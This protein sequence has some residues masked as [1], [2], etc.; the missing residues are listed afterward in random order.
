[1]ETINADSEDRGTRLDIWLNRHM[2]DMSRNRIQS[3]IKGGHV[4]I[5][6]QLKK[7]HYLLLGSESV[8]IERPDPQPAAIIPEALPLNI[9]HEDE[10]VIVL[11]KPPGLV[12]HPSPGHATGTLVN[13][14][15]H[16]YPELS[17]HDD[18]TRPGI[19]HRLDKDTTGVMIVARSAESAEHLVN[20]FKTRAVHKEYLAIV[21]GHIEPESGEVETLVGRSPGNRKKM[22]AH[23]EH[24]RQAV[25]RYETVERFKDAS[26]VRMTIE[27]GR[28]HQIRVHMTYLGHPVYGDRTYGKAGRK[29][30]AIAVDRQMLHSERLSLTHPIT[31]EPIEFRAPM[32]DDMRELIQGMREK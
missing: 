19:V 23:P 18:D 30:A 15:L 7:P 11:N 10:A 31:L 26:L 25:T 6:G 14:L 20:Q 8:E 1:M 9:L 4:R 28:T 16:R 3:L 5:S 29:D 17:L 22:S 32:P 2:P 24:G 12:I 13:A 21:Q 27:T